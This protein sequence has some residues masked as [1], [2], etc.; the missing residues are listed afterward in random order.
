MC[1]IFQKSV[2][3]AQE[4]TDAGIKEFA[5]LTT[6]M[7]PF[8]RDVRNICES[9]GCHLFGSR[10]TCPPAWGSYDDGVNECLSYDNILVFSACYE[11][12]DSFDIEGMQ[13][14]MRRFKITCDHV[15]NIIKSKALKRFL[16]LSAGGCSRCKQCTYPN[17]PCRFPD[18][19]YPSIEGFGI[20]VSKLA[21]KAGIAYMNGPN[22]IT[23]FG[24]ILY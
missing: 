18:N 15:H 4:A 23:Y 5:V 2:L 22:T 16:I 20:L 3:S 24:G 6:D 10:W 7:I 8:S 21:E 13:A 11:I 14:A 19:L 9:N 12:E 1:T 17:E